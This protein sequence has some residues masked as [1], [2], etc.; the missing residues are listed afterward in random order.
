MTE[1]R[2][3]MRLFQQIPQE[4]FA[5]L[6]N[7]YQ[8]LLTRVLEEM[9]AGM[10][11]VTGD[12]VVAAFPSAKQA[13]Q[14]AIAAQRAVRSHE[15]PYGHRLEMSVGLHSEEAAI[16]WIGPAEMRCEELCDAAEGGQTF[17]SPVTA[18]LLEDE[19]LGELSLLD[20]GERRT[21]RSGRSIHAY[22]L[23]DG[24]SGSS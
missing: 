1:G 2:R 19:N 7:E 22:E 18:G 9:G 21:R 13:T 10:V 14:A 4:Q 11:N 23:V 12:S 3:M 8:Q 20:L 5:A 6:L 16:R 24:G 15:W 17:V